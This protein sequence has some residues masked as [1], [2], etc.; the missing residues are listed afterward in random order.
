MQLPAKSLRTFIGA[1][2]FKTSRAFYTELGF[3]ERAIA[4]NLSLFT[5][6]G[7]L[8]F[9]LQDYYVK[10]WVENTMLFLEVENADKH[11]QQVQSLRLD[12]KFSNVKL[13]TVN[14]Q[15]WG[16][17]YYLHDPSGILWNIG[18]FK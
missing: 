14:A 16:R 8:S 15:N 11:W 1:L 17:V 5:L 10:E 4:P 3:T 18:E 9:Y 6:E 7:N 2:D 13:S 12:Q